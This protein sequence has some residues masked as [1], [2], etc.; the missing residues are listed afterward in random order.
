MHKNKKHGF[1]KQIFPN[2]NFYEGHWKNGMM[3]GEGKLVL[4]TGEIYFGSFVKGKRHGKGKLIF[5]A[6]GDVYE[7]DW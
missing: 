5:T 1:G 4:T 7:G 3:E 6:S 2:G